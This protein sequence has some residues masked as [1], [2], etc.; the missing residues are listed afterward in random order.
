MVITVA[1]P[2]PTAMANNLMQ[3]E[4]TRRRWQ[5]QAKDA[6]AQANA[7]LLAVVGSLI[8]A[9]NAYAE[10]Y[11]LLSGELQDFRPNWTRAQRQQAT[12]DYRA[13]IDPRGISN[14]IRRHLRV[15]TN[16]QADAAVLDD[17]VTTSMDR[18]IPAA[19][20]FLSNTADPLLRAKES[21]E[22][23]ARVV[24]AL[25]QA[26]T[27]EQARPVADWVT[28]TKEYLADGS[29]QLRTSNDELAM[30][31]TRLTALH[32]FTALPAGQPPR[33]KPRWRQRCAAFFHRGR[34]G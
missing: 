24:D 12:A 1:I 29:E 16:L 17:S 11:R 32:H 25:S 14:Q 31:T 26:S 9:M 22:D 6:E 4:D 30:L 5:E 33:D 13:W 2:D 20:D 7:A 8:D 34:S 28:R 21:D 15:L 18:L 27:V 19:F 3:M 10:G 23:R